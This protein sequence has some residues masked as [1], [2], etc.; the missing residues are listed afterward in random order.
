MKKQ[1]EFD[2]TLTIATGA[3]RKETRWK[4][5]EILWS[6]DKTAWAAP[7]VCTQESPL[8]LDGRVC[9]DIAIKRINLTICK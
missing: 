7:H 1:I 8:S 5:E 9:Q 2:G 4:N 3:S 6:E